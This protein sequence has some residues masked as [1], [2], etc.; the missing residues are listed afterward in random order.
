MQRLGG[1]YA[2][3]FNRRH[4]RWGHLFGSRFKSHLVVD[5]RYLIAAARYIVLNPV[6]AGITATAGEWPWSSY[7]VTAGV[8][9]MPR[10]LAADKL[11]D[12]FHPEDPDVAVAYY[13]EFVSAAANEEEGVRPL[14][15]G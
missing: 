3:H 9:R 6:R 5:R 4:A 15:R 1:M 12:E 7:R 2:E 14:Y 13:R 8:S 10:W 11:L